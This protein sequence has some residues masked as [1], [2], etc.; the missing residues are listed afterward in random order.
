MTN[1]PCPVCRK[2]AIEAFRPF[3]SS[4][5]RLI[6]LSAWLDGKYVVPGAPAEEADTVPGEQE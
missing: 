1:T 2:P 5:C 3:C 4:R 6:D